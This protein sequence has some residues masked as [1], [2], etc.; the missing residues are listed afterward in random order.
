EQ[1]TGDDYRMLVFEGRCLSVLHRERPHVIG[2]GHDTIASLIR[3]ENAR[4]VTSTNWSPGDPALIPLKTDRR[5]RRFLASQGLTLETV[6]AAGR[7]VQLS[8]LANYGAGASYRELL[9]QTHPNIVAGAE[10]AARAAGV[11]LAGI[12]VITPDIAGATYVIN[13]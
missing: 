8:P 13:E 12:D 7:K 2:N 11:T 6:P 5:T 10:A 1:V 4:R 9:R 3:R